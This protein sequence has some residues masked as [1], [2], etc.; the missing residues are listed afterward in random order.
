MASGNYVARENAEKEYNHTKRN[1]MH[2]EEWYA[3][4]GKEEIVTV[5]GQTFTVVLTLDLEDG[6]FTVECREKPAAITRGK[7]EEEALDNL[8]N[9]LEWCLKQEG[10]WRT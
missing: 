1:D 5:G 2:D 9:A 4:I 3:K 8:I 7:T 6:G 10:D